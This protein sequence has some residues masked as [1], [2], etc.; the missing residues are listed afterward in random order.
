ML[1]EGIYLA[2]STFEAGFVSSAHGERE[3]NATLEA[4]GRVMY[5]IAT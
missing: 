2:P 3:I 5:Q 4:A 1:S